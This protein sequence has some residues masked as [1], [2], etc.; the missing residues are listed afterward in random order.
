MTGFLLVLGGV[1]GALPDPVAN[2]AL[3][4]EVGRVRVVVEDLELA[5]ELLRLAQNL[6]IV[7]GPLGDIDLH[8]VGEVH[9]ERDSVV[10]DA[11]VED[12]ASE[13]FI[14]PELIDS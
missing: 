11:R 12:D 14:L 13:I 10:V 9:G 3:D 6:G 2:L 1:P 7:G 5:R 4:D 8:G